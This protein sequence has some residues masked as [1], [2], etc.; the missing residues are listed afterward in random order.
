[1]VVNVLIPGDQRGAVEHSGGHKQTIKRIPSPVQTDRMIDNL[2]N[3]VWRES[4]ADVRFQR[5]K[6]LIR[7]YADFLELLQECQLQTD[8]GGDEQCGTL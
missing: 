3:R 6:N 7:T 5:I 2:I 4:Q 1:M 8:G